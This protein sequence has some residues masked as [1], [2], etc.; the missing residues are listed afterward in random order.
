MIGNA[1]FPQDLYLARGAD[2]V[3]EPATDETA[4]VRWV[5]LDEAATMI[6]SGELVGAASIIGVQYALML[7]AGIQLPGQ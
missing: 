4:A 6:T 3:R 5:P 1:D 2:L 7:R